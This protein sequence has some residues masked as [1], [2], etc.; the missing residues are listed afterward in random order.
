MISRARAFALAL[1]LAAATPV[2][3]CAQSLTPAPVPGPVGLSVGN[4]A[5]MAVFRAE[6]WLA[7]QP[8]PAEGAAADKSVSPPP[9]DPNPYAAHAPAEPSAEEL[10]LLLPLLQDPD[11]PLPAAESDPYTAYAR[12]ALSLSRHTPPLLVTAEAPPL[13]WRN[14]LLH[15]L[16][17][18]QTIDP[19]GGGYWQTP[20]QDPCATTLTALWTLHHL[21]ALPDASQ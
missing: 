7:R 14:F 21:L 19:R 8:P 1:F 3:L 5:R 6:R 10:Q 4:E 13:P 9:A 18:R 17:T 12:L 16:V 2:L 11:A 15:L 20:S